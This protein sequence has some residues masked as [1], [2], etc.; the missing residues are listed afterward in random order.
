M[1]EE[2]SATPNPENQE[3]QQDKHR[4]KKGKSFN[5]NTF[6]NFIILIGLIFIYLLYF[7]QT[8]KETQPQNPNPKITHVQSH[9]GIKI[10][11][12]NTDSIKSH[13]SLVADMESKLRSK[14]NQLQAEVTAKE[15][16]LLDK[17]KSLQ[18]KYDLNII[19]EKEAKR[20]NDELQNE[21]QDLYELKQ[22][23]TDQLSDAEYQMNLDFIDSVYNYLK[24]F[25]KDVGFDYILGYSKGSNIL[26]AKDTFDI[27]NIVIEGLNKEYREEFP[28]KKKK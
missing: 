7:M 19:S 28:E 12:V 6:L 3:V 25:N 21:S 11:F 13:Y 22:K 20:Q 9:E 2:N 5:L 27:T 16:K 1:S 10:A 24:R 15:N 18:N 23:Y 26:F 14:Y 17:S 8:K 4:E